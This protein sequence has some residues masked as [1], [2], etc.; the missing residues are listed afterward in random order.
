MVHYQNHL[1]LFGGYTGKERLSDVHRL[2]LSNFHRRKQEER[3]K[4]RSKKVSF[5][6]IFSLFVVFRLQKQNFVQIL[7]LGLFLLICCF[8]SVVLF[9]L[10]FFFSIFQIVLGSKTWTTMVVSG[11]IPNKKMCSTCVIA[12]ESQEK[13]Q[14]KM[15]K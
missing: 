3:R 14:N 4:K 7:V 15:K 13:R 1:F 5:L 2:N 11:E 10:S 6:H 12:P 8:I 9:Y